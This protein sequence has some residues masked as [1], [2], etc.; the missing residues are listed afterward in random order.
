MTARA[1]PALIVVPAS[2][3][4]DAE[5][6]AAFILLARRVRQKS[7]FLPRLMVLLAAP[8]DDAATPAPSGPRDQGRSKPRHAAAVLGVLLLGALALWSSAGDVMTAL[9]LLPLAVLAADFFSAFAHWALDHHVPLTSGPLAPLAREF[10][11]HH[12]APDSDQFADKL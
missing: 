8:R 7:G 2:D 11:D 5:A 6:L 10:R 12:R 9:A 3:G 4:V 1:L